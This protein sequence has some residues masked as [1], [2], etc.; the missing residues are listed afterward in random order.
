MLNHLIYQKQY[1]HMIQDHSITPTKHTVSNIRKGKWRNFLR[2]IYTTDI[3]Q[4]RHVHA[5]LCKNEKRVATFG[6]L[7]TLS[8]RASCK[9]PKHV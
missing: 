3:L 7:A 5:F 2:H 6:T 1:N 8:N 4:K 9:L